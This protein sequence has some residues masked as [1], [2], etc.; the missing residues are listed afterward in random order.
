M[1][2]IKYFRKL[3]GAEKVSLKGVVP[4]G[5]DMVYHG[6]TSSRMKAD[7]TPEYRAGEITLTL[8]NKRVTTT[9]DNPEVM[10][11]LSEGFKAR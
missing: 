10:K 11:R 7:G 5:E 3:G 1:R 6:K 4:D 9:L 2:V 8:G